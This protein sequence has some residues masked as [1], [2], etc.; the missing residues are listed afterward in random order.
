MIYRR[1]AK[2]DFAK[3]SGIYDIL[4]I[5]LNKCFHTNHEFSV[6]LKAVVAEGG[7][8]CERDCFK[9]DGTELLSPLNFLLKCKEI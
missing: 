7:N 6:L 1:R 3:R 5:V 4:N 8:Y 2:F 9:L